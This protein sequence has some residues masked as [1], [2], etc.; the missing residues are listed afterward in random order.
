MVQFCTSTITVG[1][2]MIVS[3]GVFTLYYLIE[4]CNVVV[5]IC[6]Y[7]SFSMIQHGTVQSTTETLCICKCGGVLW[8]ES[9]CNFPFAD[10]AHPQHKEWV[11]LFLVFI[12]YGVYHWVLQMSWS[13]GSIPQYHSFFPWSNNIKTP[14]DKLI[15]FADISFTLLIVRCKRTVVCF[16]DK[17]IWPLSPAWGIFRISSLS[18]GTSDKW[19]TTI[20]WFVWRKL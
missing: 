10:W 15:L 3:V 17:E 12:C 16:T 18:V 5:W 19:Q 8:F 14:K 20:I 9:R 4:S 11:W 2:G 13:G 1:Y 7:D 6:Q